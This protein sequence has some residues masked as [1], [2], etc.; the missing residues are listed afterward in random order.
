M[1]D[2]PPPPPP[3]GSVPPSSGGDVPDTLDVGTALS[4]GWKKF[5]E[6]AVPLVLIALVLI[7]GLFFGII[8][9]F[10]LARALGLFGV[11]L[12]ELGLVA[13]GF[14]FAV[15]IYQAGLEI[16]AGRTVVVSEVFKTPHFGNFVACQILVAL[17]VFVGT[18]LCIIP[19]VAA[20][21][22]L[23]FAPF[24]VLD[25]GQSATQAIRSSYEIV[26]ANLGA[27]LVLLIVSYLVYAV[28]AFIC[29]IG[30]LIS[31]PVALL[32]I[33]YAYRRLNAQPVAP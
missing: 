29:G 20:A 10:I 5:T 7:V 28:G 18:I 14:I 30:A 24:Y 17:A 23:A 32:M 33:S 13:L 21:I 31:G 3:P 25:Q 8:V 4:Y 26:R 2:V 9:F 11:V 6:N 12:G 15:G 27:V 1:S 22:L 16:T 19:G